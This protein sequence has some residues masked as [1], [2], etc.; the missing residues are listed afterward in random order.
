MLKGI[1]IVRTL[2]TSAGGNSAKQHQ[3]SVFDSSAKIAQKS[4]I[5]KLNPTLS[6]KT[7][8][9]RDDVAL[10]TVERLAFITRDFPKVL[11]FGSHLGNLLKVLCQETKTPE[12]ADE[13]EM[14]IIK[15]LNEDKKLVRSKIK[16]LVMLEP[17]SEMLYRDVNEPFNSQFEG[18]I[19]RYVADAE[20]F[21]S[22]CMRD[23]EQYDA[24]ISNLSLHWINDLPSVLANINRVLKPDGLFMG[25]ILGGDTL[26]ELR[27]SLQL[28]ELERRGG[29]TPR[30]SPLVKLND[31]GTLLNR[32]GF[33][34]LTIDPQ[35]IVVG[36]FPNI[37]AVCEDLE[38]MGEQNALL[39]RSGFIPRDVLLAANEIYKA[40]HGEVNSDGTLTL[41]VT[42]NVMFMIG[43]KKGENQPKPLAR[44]SGEVNLKDVL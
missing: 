23:P 8:Y 3:Y 25:T 6:R 10:K 22:E 1:K 37:I 42:F 20:T 16:E 12:G 7:E 33:N 14:A 29:I 26:Y 31:V 35:D 17:S 19:S 44:G 41:P 11:D 38:A 30:V 27:T 13:V 9:L 15:Q 32:A 5:A 4:R 34:M 2:A 36:G 24:V 40:L 18:K 28:A 21:D 39:S 43:W